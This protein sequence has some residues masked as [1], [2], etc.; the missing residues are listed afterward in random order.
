M[1]FNMGCG[2][3]RLDGWRNVDASP[4]CHPDEVV[5]LEQ[6]PWPWADNCAAEIRF[7]HSLEH[8]GG[9]PK[10]FLALMQELYRIAAPDC[11]VRIDVPHPRHDNFLNDPTHVRPITPDLM[12]LFDREKNDQWQTQG[13]EN[14]PLA[15]YLSVDFVLETVKIKLDQPWRADLEQGR[16]TKAEVDRAVRLY[17]NVAS[18]FYLVLRARK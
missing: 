16:I 15:H 18:D 10:V 14:T 9:D 7:H 2:H 17:N 4:I 13:L 1:R 6:T 3:N 8:M 12:R 5:D 11:V